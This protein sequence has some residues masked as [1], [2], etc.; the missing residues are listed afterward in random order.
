M[1]ERVVDGLEVVEVEEQYGDARSGP[2]ARN[3]SPLH[4]ID[5]QGP[6]G[7]LREAVVK[8]LVL[9]LFFEELLLG[10]VVNDA[11]EDKG[12]AGHVADDGRFVAH[13]HHA[14]VSRE[15]A[16]D[17]LEAQCLLPTRGLLRKDALAI[18]GVK[19]GVHGPLLMTSS[20]V[21]PRTDRTCGLT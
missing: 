18:V 5:E 11:L 17:A 9:E 6:V 19:L 4:A 16:I 1:A 7:E 15:Q 8:R 20:G 14:A 12:T 10:D 13:P 3:E 21:K 2:A